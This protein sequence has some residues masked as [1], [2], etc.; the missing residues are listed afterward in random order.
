MS[1]PA[2][3]DSKTRPYKADFSADSIPQMGASLL[4]FNVQAKYR[5][6]RLI[7]CVTAGFN[8][9]FLRNDIA[10]AAFPA[11]VRQ[12][13]FTAIF[14]TFRSVTNPR[15]VSLTFRARTSR[16]SRGAGAKRRRLNGSMWTRR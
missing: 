8:A 1:N 13:R 16:N 10:P 7:G 12:R 15:A 6:Y 2:S 11:Y 5:G 3:Q 14:V 4:A 9:L